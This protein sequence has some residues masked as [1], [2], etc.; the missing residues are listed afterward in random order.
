MILSHGASSYFL[1]LEVEGGGGG[2]GKHVS[3]P[4]PFFDSAS[5]GCSIPFRGFY[6]T[7]IYACWGWKRFIYEAYN[8]IICS[9][10][11][12]LVIQIVSRYVLTNRP[13]SPWDPGYESYYIA[14][15]REYLIFPG[16]RQTNQH[17]DF[18]MPVLLKAGELRELWYTPSL[19]TCIS[20]L[21]REFKLCS[22]NQTL[23]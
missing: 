7:H 17:I 8:T 20:Q 1:Y 3:V 21:V 16:K 12:V 11:P 14:Q 19:I 5:T 4:S 22:F 9:S 10:C 23:I 6:K 15:S 13:V 18:T 2:G